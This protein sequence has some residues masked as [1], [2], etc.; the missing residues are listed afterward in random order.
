MTT[1]NEQQ[2]ERLKDLL[3][4]KSLWQVY[5]S[6]RKIPFS[7]I[8]IAAG[9]IV[10]IFVAALGLSAKSTMVL[11]DAL[12]AFAT[13]GFSLCIAQLGF[14]L[15]G[16]S[17][18]ATVADK[19]MFCRM[20][21]K[22]HQASGLSYLKYNFLVFM[23]VFVEYLVF[24]LACLGMMVLLTKDIGLRETVSGWMNNWQTAKLW[25]AA[26]TFGLFVGCVVYL[27]M[28]LA[29][30]IYNIYHVVMTCIR[31]ELQKDYEQQNARSNSDE[32]ASRTMAAE[33]SPPAA[34]DTD[35]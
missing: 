1:F 35:R 21:D 2:N 13:M 20:A 14:L 15:A 5:V 4:E 31:W 34:G 12:L 26:V 17:F 25:I 23:R 22:T 7:K 28:Q 11:A 19:E 27:L 24:C 29:S 8:N 6:S 10:T 33:S 16:F 32:S 3:K 30:F 18:F 9:L